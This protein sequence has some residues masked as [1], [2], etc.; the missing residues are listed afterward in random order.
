MQF[1]SILGGQF[2]SIL[3]H[4]ISLE[5]CGVWVKPSGI[6][7]GFIASNCCVDTGSSSGRASPYQRRS[8]ASSVMPTLERQIDG[9]E[10][11]NRSLTEGKG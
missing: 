4:S 2:Y 9:G 7:E 1:V 11:R 8:A 10:E 5:G 3:L 6:G